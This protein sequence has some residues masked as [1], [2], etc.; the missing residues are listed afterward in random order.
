MNLGLMCR[1]PIES[2]VASGRASGPIAVVHQKGPLYSWAN[3]SLCN[4]SAHCTMS[5][6]LHEFQLRH[7]V[8]KRLV[9][10]NEFLEIYISWLP[11]ISLVHY[12]CPCPRRVGALCNDGRC[13]S[14]LSFCLPICP[15]PNSRSRTD[16]CSELKIGRSEAHDMGDTWPHLEVKV[17]VSLC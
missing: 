5:R 17:K 11:C 16:G 8:C 7:A 14:V 10:R 3:P 4:E 9:M 1:H 15:M 13:L 12:L 6:G 2:L